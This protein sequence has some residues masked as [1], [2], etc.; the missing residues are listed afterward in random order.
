M[1]PI[2]NSVKK[3]HENF[4]RLV[5]CYL[6][7]RNASRERLNEEARTFGIDVSVAPPDN[8]LRYWIVYVITLMASVYI[9]VLVSAV[10]CDWFQKHEL[11]LRQD[12]NLAINWMMYSLSNYGLAIV[13][14][15]L[16]RF[17]GGPQLDRS[18]LITYCWTFLVALVVGPFGLTLAVHFFGPDD[19]RKLQVPQLFFEMLKWGL[20]P[21]LV[22]V[23]ISYYLDRQTARDLPDI[24]HSYSTR[25][26]RLLN[27]FGFAAITVF[28]LLPSLLS[29]PYRGGPW[30]EHKLQF[31][32]TGSTFFVAFGLALAAQFALRK[33]GPAGAP[34][35]TP[36][37]GGL[38]TVG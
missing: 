6:I 34:V 11:V 19:L 3:L 22:C 24:D 4:S 1:G 27:C 17:I 2:A 10:A 37:A 28:L 25:L 30:D 31:V 32:A 18:H 7:Y 16:I 9:G 26:R 29:I 8:P 13:V 35:V 15:L 20:G 33:R 21:A 38:A 36:P 23:Y 5:A 14:I 12:A